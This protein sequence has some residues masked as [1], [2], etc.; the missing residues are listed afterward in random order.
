V[1]ATDESS[2]ICTR[3]G[4]SGGANEDF[5][6]LREWIRGDREAGATLFERHVDVVRRFFANKVADP[7]DLVQSTF[8]ACFERADQFEG[9][10][11]F[12]SYLLRIARFKLYHH[13]RGR[14][15][16]RARVHLN[17]SAPFHS[18]DPSPSAVIGCAD[19]ER[20]LLQALRMIPLDLQVVLELVYWEELSGHELSEVLEVPVNTVY[21]RVHRAKQK[22]RDAL[23]L[24]VPAP[25]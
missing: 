3:D 7:A 16:Q 21:G 10:S 5:A 14:S 18:L 22:L 6:L 17:T 1:R 19:D 25:T 4:G 24:L 20:L 11:S 15:P 2:I 9:R 8:L 23:S 13:Y 12:R